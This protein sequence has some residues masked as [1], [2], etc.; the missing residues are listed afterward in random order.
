MWPIRS[1]FGLRTAVPS[2]GSL[3][4]SWCGF[5]MTSVIII[6]LLFWVDE[7][8]L[9]R[10]QPPGSTRAEPDRRDAGLRNRRRPVRAGAAFRR[11][12][13][14]ALIVDQKRRERRTAVAGGSGAAV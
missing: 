1:P 7:M 8:E 3:E 9:T 6:T 14:S 5:V 2:T 10:R 13:A 4:I 11:S 12:V